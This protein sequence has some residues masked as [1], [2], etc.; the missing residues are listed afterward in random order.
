MP[1]RMSLFL[2]VVQARKKTNLL[3]FPRF[4]LKGIF[5]L[6]IQD[7]AKPNVEG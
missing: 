2:V 3:L 6:L 4:L 5:F 7:E 1:Q